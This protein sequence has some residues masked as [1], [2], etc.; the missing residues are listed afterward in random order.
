MESALKRFHADD[1]YD[2][3]I[4]VISMSKM[5]FVGIGGFADSI[6]RYTI[7]G[8]TQRLTNNIVFP[9]GTLLINLGGC[10]IIGLL[11]Q[12]GETRIIFTAELCAFIFIGILGGF[13]TFSTFGNET[14]D[15]WREGDSL[16]ALCNVAAHIVLGLGAVWMG[17]VLARLALICSG[18]V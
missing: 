8:L 5:W 3:R 13:T 17:R 12:L 1:S 9:Y 4:G 11:S 6:F 2:F 14:M 16:L 7:D 18:R 10:L 15:L